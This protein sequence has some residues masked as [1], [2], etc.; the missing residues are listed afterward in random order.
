MIAGAKKEWLKM[1]GVNNILVQNESMEI[2]TIMNQDCIKA[3][4]GIPDNTV[5][6][7]VTDPPLI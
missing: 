4:T 5:D 2:N 3:M 6:L 7:I 1:E